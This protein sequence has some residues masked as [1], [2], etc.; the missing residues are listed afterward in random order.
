MDED[1]RHAVTELPPNITN[2]CMELTTEGALKVGELDDLDGRIRSPD[3]DATRQHGFPVVDVLR[4]PLSIESGD[5]LLRA[6]ELTVRNRDGNDDRCDR[7]QDGECRFDSMVHSSSLVV[8][9]VAEA[10][11]DVR[12]KLEASRHGDAPALLIVRK[13]RASAPVSSVEQLMLLNQGLA[14][15]CARLVSYVLTAESISCGIRAYDSRFQQLIRT[16]PPEHV[17][18]VAQL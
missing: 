7:E 1:E 11:P 5:G 17:P 13:H 6:N 12:W 4:R 15:T 16:F 8:K 10:A 14:T 3:V 9:D 2:A 18:N